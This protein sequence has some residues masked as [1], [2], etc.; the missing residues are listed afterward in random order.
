MIILYHGGGATMSELRG[1]VLSAAEWEQ[2]QIAAKNLLI[3]RH[4]KSTAE[5]LTKYPFEL[6]EG[7][8]DFSDEVNVLYG[9]LALDQYVQLA[10]LKEDPDTARNLKILAETMSELGHFVRFIAISMNKDSQSVA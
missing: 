4:Q 10:G 1:E 3:A 7:T 9:S 2:F 8:N 6:R 5:L